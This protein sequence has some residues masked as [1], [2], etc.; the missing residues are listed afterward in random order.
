MLATTKQAQKQR[1]QK[2]GFT[3]IEL[4][5]V[6]AIIA[7]LV[8]L[9]L[10]AVQQARE[11]ARRSSC[12]NNLK[13]MVLA[14]HNYENQY[15]KYP[16]GGTYNGLGSSWSV[17]V[18]IA[19]FIEQGNLTS[20]LDLNGA[21]G[22]EGSPAAIA[23]IP[24]YLCPSDPGDHLR[25]KNG[26]KQYYPLTY[27]ANYGT[28]FV[29]NP[30]TGKG[31][32]GV[33]Y[34][35]SKTKQAHIASA[36]GMTNTLAFAEVKAYSPYVR[37]GGDFKAN[38]GHTEW[39]DARVHQSGFTAKL[40]PNSVGTVPSGQDVPFADTTSYREGKSTD[41][42]T[43]ADVT[44]RSYHTGGVHAAL[45][46]G[47]VRFVSNDILPATWK[48]LADRADGKAISDPNFN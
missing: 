45:M 2:S 23:R 16:P 27:G 35:N 34:P 48:N 42:I 4:L 26:V 33:F 11:A 5:V 46:D 44:A 13:Q 37:D 15:G 29:Y 9:L 6:I 12:K 8:A 1:P 47:S 17:Q 38:S 30:K 39:I 14:L 19:P 18:R 43:D 41:Q 36:D 24:T 3:L 40:T 22:G 7:V 31:G 10:P 32:A 20:G 25:E 28:G 21:Y